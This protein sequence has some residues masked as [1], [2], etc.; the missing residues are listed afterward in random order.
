MTVVN[1]QLNVAAG[2][3]TMEV[4]PYVGAGD[5]GKVNTPIPRAEINFQVNSEAIAVATGGDSQRLL[6]NCALPLSFA[7]VVQEISIYNLAGVD[8]GDWETVASCRIRNT[9]ISGKTWA[10]SFDLWSRGTYSASPTTNTARSY[11]LSSPGDLNRLVIPGSNANL[12]VGV[13]NPTVDGTAM[14]IDGFLARFLQFDI[15]QAYFYG[16]N[17]PLPVR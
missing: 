9:A 17:T 2:N 12:D 4:I 16:A 1:T 5:M 13:S 15:N 7:Y 14:S 11:H 6:I 3:M 8:A 10:H